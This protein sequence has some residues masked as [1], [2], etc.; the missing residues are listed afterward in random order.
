[1]QC[2]STAD[3]LDRIQADYLE[4]PGLKLTVRQARRLWDLPLESCE[5]ALAT[6]VES[7]FL[8]RSQDGAFLRGGSLLRSLAALRSSD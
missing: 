6:L 4:M 8:V 5:S 7:G 1:M 3:L 2:L